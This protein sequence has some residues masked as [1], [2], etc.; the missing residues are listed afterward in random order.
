MSIRA[1]SAAL[2]LV[3][4]T[5]AQAAPP[6][7]LVIFG[8]SLV[9]AGNAFIGTGGAVASPAQGYFMGRFTNGPTYVDILNQELF[10]SLTTPFLAGG[11]NFA[12]GGARAAIPRDFP[13]LG[14]VPSLPQQLGIYLSS[15]GGVADPDAFYII[16][17]GNNDVGA[18]QSGD[19]G[20]LSDAQ[21][22]QTFVGNIVGS[23]NTLT[24]LGARN[25]LVFGVPDPR[26][27]EGVLLQDSLDSALD[28]LTP[29]LPGGTSL[30]RFDAMDFFTRVDQTRGAYGI[31]GDIDIDAPC[32]A[33]RP[34]VNGQIDCSGFFS[35]DGTHPVDRIH[36]ALA[37]E[38]GD[39]TGLADIPEPG[40]WAMLILGFGIAG[41]GLRLRSRA[42][43]A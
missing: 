6:S 12:V 26:D 8:D 14:V 15:T 9:D 33:F 22:V 41:A 27:P 23:I 38:V 36:F 37:R 1:I 19:Q 20:G 7:K 18:L 39:L 10:G 13:G 17:F 35:F 16:N 31:D 25:F 3:A 29:L 30:F 28:I 11:T 42:A 40:T 24:G 2:L 4:A 5:A 32:I 43:T 21:Y 34:V